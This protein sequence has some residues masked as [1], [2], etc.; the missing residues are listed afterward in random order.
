MSVGPGPA[1]GMSKG[2]GGVMASTA[3][4]PGAMQQERKKLR[5]VLT[6]FDL[7]FFT[8]AAFISLDTIAVTA[9]Y[10]GGETFFWLVVTILVLA[11]AL[12]HD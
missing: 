12:R 4:Q 7:V 6:R 8:I 2:S 5:K 10:G 3:D 11:R 9:A 1:A